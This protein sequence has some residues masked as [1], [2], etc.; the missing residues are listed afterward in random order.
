[1]IELTG[2]I[3]HI[4]LTGKLMV[5]S[6]GRAEPSLQD[7]VVIPTTA[8]Q[9]IEADPGYDG[10]ESVTVAGDENFIPKN[11]LRGKK[12]WGLVGTGTISP[13]SAGATGGIPMVYMG[14]ARS[15]GLDCTGMFTTSAVGAVRE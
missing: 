7:K 1:M 6:A 5:D 11:I 13:I 9:F 15:T 4:K 3:K 8:E 2:Y 10:L 14:L 12:I